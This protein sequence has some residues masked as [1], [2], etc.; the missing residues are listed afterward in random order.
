MENFTNEFERLNSIKGLM[1]IIIFSLSYVIRLRNVY[2]TCTSQ[3][4]E[5]NNFFSAI[6]PLNFQ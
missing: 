5:N 1:G 6:F 2:I 3:N 4:N